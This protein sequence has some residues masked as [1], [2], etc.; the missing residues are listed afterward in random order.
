MADCDWLV[1]GSFSG[2]LF[3]VM[4]HGTLWAKNS[5]CSPMRVIVMFMT[6]HDH[7]VQK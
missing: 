4:D 3:P 1:K 7:N 2:L 5:K 6:M